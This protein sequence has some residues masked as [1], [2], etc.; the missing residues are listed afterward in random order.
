V[1]YMTA[2]SADCFR[3]TKVWGSR[4][5]F[6]SRSNRDGESY[7]GCHT[8][9]HRTYGSR[10]AANKLAYLETPVD[11]S[12]THLFLARSEE[13]VTFNDEYLNYWGTVFVASLSMAKYYFVP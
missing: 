10:T 6:A 2:D 7:P 4:S 3:N 1:N 9:P 8:L 5:P 13:S 12:C 11:S